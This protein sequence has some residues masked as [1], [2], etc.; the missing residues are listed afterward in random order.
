MMSDGVFFF[1]SRRRHTRYWRDWSSDV[2]SS[3]LP[4]DRPEALGEVTDKRLLGGIRLGR[5]APFLLRLA[6]RATARQ[7]PEKAALAGLADVP[8]ADAAVLDQ[9]PLRA[10]HGPG[11]GEI[12]SPP[13]APGPGIVA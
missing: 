1:S 8:P 5:R 4:L 3:D 12:P 13:Q 7:E 11:T 10:L 2:C 9:P 6:L